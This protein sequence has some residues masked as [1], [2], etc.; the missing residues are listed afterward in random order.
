MFWFLIC[1]REVARTRGHALCAAVM[2]SNWSAA[3]AS[4]VG[5]CFEIGSKM[6]CIPL[7]DSTLGQFPAEAHC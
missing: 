5:I 4:T 1:L 6:V 7:A 3:S 2:S